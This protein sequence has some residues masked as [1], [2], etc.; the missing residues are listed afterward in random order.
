[1]ALLRERAGEVR[2]RVG[3]NTQE[4]AV[5]VDSLPG[6]VMMTKQHLATGYVVRTSCMIPYSMTS[7]FNYRFMNASDRYPDSSLHRRGFVYYGEHLGSCEYE[8]VPW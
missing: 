1:M 4:S 6:G 2:I 3:G 7:S 5:L 8:M